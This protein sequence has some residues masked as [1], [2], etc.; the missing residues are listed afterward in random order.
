MNGRVYRRND[1]VCESCLTETGKFHNAPV[2]LH[3]GTGGNYRVVWAC[4]DHAAAEGEP[5]PRDRVAA[6]A[7]P[8]TR[9][10]TV[11]TDHDLAWRA[12]NTDEFDKETTEQILALVA[13]RD[14]A[15]KAELDFKDA[16]TEW[17]RKAK[18]AEAEVKFLRQ[19][20]E[21]HGQ[22]SPVFDKEHK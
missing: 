4:V 20:I 11:A 17:M 10:A 8:T 16:A 7:L 2:E 1:H 5:W 6:A 13:E 12:R 14:E 15:V 18:A 21:S 22:D 9:G 3:V 19:W